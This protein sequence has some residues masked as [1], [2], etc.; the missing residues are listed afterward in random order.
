MSDGTQII[1]I[2]T[3][4]G[5]TVDLPLMYLQCVYGQKPSKHSRDNLKCE[6]PVNP[7]FC[8]EMWGIRGAK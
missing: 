6:V 8:G 2:R 1:S 4:S 3:D 7:F 5:G